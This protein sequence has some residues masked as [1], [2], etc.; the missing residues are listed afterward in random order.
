MVAAG[1]GQSKPDP[2]TLAGAAAFVTGGIGTIVAAIG[3]FGADDSALAAARRNHVSLLIA[4]ASAAALGLMLGGL[5]GILRGPDGNVDARG[6]RVRVL[7]V[8]AVIAVAAG[9]GLGVYATADRQ[10]GQPTIVLQRVNDESVRVE[11]TAEGL[12]SDAWFAAVLTG[13]SDSTVDTN[14]VFL[15]SARFS[16]GQDGKLD[17][18]ERFDVPAARDGKPITR[19]LVTIARDEPVRANNCTVSS[20]VIDQAAT[21][22]LLR[23]PS[24]LEPTTS[25]S[26]ETPHK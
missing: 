18:Q 6:G 17:W 1:G 16:P 25:T 24:T 2:G 21:C 15:A 23:V 19:V 9:V 14:G 12:P 13:Y 4:A 26:L 3:S 22:L 5:Y 11:I 7:L 10:P 8:V 20:S